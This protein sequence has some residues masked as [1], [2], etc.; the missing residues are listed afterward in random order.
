MSSSLY[1]FILTSLAAMSTL[2]GTFF[3][4]FN[5]QNKK[6]IIKSSLFLAAIIMIFVS[7]FSLIPESINYLLY[8][9]KL[10]PGI[11]FCIIFFT[12]GIIISFLINNFIE[13]K[14]KKQVLYKVGLSSMVAI[15][16]HNIP[17]G[18]ATFMASS[19]NITLG[20]SLSIAIF[21]HNIPEGISIAIPI[22]YSTNSKFKACLFTFISA[23]AEPLGALVSYL[24]LASFIN[25]FIM[26]LILSLV[27]GI[28]LHISFYE[29]IPT[30]LT[31]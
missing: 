23:L 4:F 26:G 16:L 6:L 11:C 5:F 29:L 28:M 24:F 7:V 21:L 27:A 9:L 12:I 31:Y 22:Y 18:I 13:L 17:E 30:A 19:K 2:F 15:I 14:V 25:N 8:Y 20:L 10:F 3:I 1:A